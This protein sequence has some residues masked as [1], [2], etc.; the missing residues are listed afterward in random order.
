MRGHKNVISLPRSTWVKVI[1]EAD[2]K[3]ETVEK[4]DYLM[5]R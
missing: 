2:G 1:G 4:I 3:I 5:N